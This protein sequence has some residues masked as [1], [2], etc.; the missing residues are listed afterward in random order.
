MSLQTDDLRRKRAN[1]IEFLCLRFPVPKTPESSRSDEM[2]K[3]QD[4]GALW[5]RHVVS[6]NENKWES[7]LEVFNVDWKRTGLINKHFRVLGMPTLGGRDEAERERER[8]LTGKKS[9]ENP[10]KSSQNEKW[11]ASPAPPTPPSCCSWGKGR[12][13]FFPSRAEGTFPVDK[14]P[15]RDSKS[16]ID[17]SQREKLLFEMA[18][19]RWLCDYGSGITR[20]EDNRDWCWAEKLFSGWCGRSRATSH[21][22]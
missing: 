19:E 12:E 20:L 3:S 21:I 11:F 17:K 4:E 8:A 1:F 18:R 15:R 22:N 13:K 16:Q 10:K 2:M 9:K 5:A 14:L 6:V 7:I